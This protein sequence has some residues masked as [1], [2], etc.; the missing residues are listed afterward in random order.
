MIVDDHSAF[1]ASARA[2]LELDGFE[3]VGE[4]Q[5]GRSAVELA[6]ELEPDLVLLDVVLPDASGFDVAERLKDGRSKVI[7]ISSREQR[8][9]GQRVQRSAALG[10]VSK[11]S[12]SGE[13]LAT[14]LGGAG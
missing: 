11:D 3:V 9:Y 1:R 6:N 13:A 8:D 12:L 2:A 5:D 4:A 7:L 10:F 14:M